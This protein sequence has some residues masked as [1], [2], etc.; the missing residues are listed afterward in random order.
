MRIYDEMKLLD[1]CRALLREGMDSLLTIENENRALE[2]LKALTTF[3]INSCTTVINIK[4]FYIKLQQLSIIGDKEK[5]AEKLDE[6]EALL[7]AERKNAEDT[8]PAVQTDSR[9]GWEAMQDYLCDEAAL[10]WK[11]R[12]IDY[13][14]EFELPKFRKSNSL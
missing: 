7:I 10:R 14:L 8:I 6:I 4:E 12:Q 1:K 11:L 9:L 13:E 3:M 2:K 5:A